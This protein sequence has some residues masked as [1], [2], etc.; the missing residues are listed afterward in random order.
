MAASAFA[1][2]SA[3]VVGYQTKAMRTGYNFVAPDFTTIGVD[4]IDVQDIQLNANA[5]TGEENIQ[6]LSAS[7][8]TTA[9]YNWAT[10]A[11]L[12]AETGAW[13]DDEAT[14]VEATLVQGDG[15]LL[16]VV[17]PN[18]EVTFAGEVAPDT[19]T[20]NLRTGYNFTGNPFPAAIDVQAIQLNANGGT[21][22]E[23]IQIL[24]ASGGTTAMYNWATAADLEAETGAWVNDEAELVEASIAAGDGFLLAVVNS[25]VVVTI[26]SGIT[27]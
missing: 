15:F 3:N 18:V 27:L 21:G 6:I 19:V 2:E 22:E 17:N 20:V 11:D 26:P 5:G 7:G 14:L 12:E 23:N 8:G 25:G 10:A 1:V 9:M 4:T 16:A 13:V 24:S